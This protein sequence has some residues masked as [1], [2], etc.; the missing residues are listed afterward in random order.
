MVIFG[1]FLMTHRTHKSK[2]R[3]AKEEDMKIL[4]SAEVIK[5]TTFEI[6]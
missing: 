1:S 6:R 3:F 5:A 2:S 4:R